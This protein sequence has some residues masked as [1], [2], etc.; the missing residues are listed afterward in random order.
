M[1]KFKLAKLLYLID[2]KEWQS[3]GEILTGYYYIFQ[4]NGPLPTGLSR[5]L[6]DMEGNEVYFR[7]MGS[8][9]GYSLGR[10]IRTSMELPIEISNKLDEILEKYGELTDSKIKTTVYLTK[11]I[12]ELFRRRLNGESVLNYPVF[13]S[14]G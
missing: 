7:W 2:W 10:N 8:E 11:P 9:P 3:H 12:K 1:T 14:K 4:K 6:E 13:C 5:N